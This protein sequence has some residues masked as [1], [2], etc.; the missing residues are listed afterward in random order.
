MTDHLIEQ[1]EGAVVT[2]T[3]NRPE[4]LNA[5]S[6]KMMMGLLEALPRLSNDPDVGVIILTGAGRGFCAGG[7]V[8]G[9]AASNSASSAD[10]AP[11]SMEDR[12]RGLRDSMEISRYLHECA[13][14][15]IAMIRGPAAGAGLSMALACDIRMA[16]E[17][18]MFTTAFAKVGFSGDFGGSYFLTHLVGTAKA[19]ELYLT[20]DKVRSSEALQLGMVN[21]LVPDDEL[22]VKTM[23]LAHRIANGPR[24]ANE[25]I[26]KNLNAA[27]NGTLQ[28]VFDLEAWHMTRTMFT[29]DHKEAAQAFVEKRT[30]VF[31]G[32]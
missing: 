25:Y 18:S 13:K 8:K 7:D 30:P 5:L 19:R 4:S 11:A 10:K 17:N 26:K 21:H 3:M 29:E 28:Q 20:A 15:T 14:P 27:E 1:K 6:G 24:I 12:A 2:L 32:R 23:E 31:K 16:S 9:M 22:E